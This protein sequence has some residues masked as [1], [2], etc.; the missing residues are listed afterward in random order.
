MCKMKESDHKSHYSHDWEMGFRFSDEEKVD[1]LKNSITVSR[2][3]M[4]VWMTRAITTVLLWTCFVQLMALGELWRPKLFITW[5]SRCCH[6]DSPMALQSSSSSLPYK[7]FLPPKSKL[8]VLIL[9]HFSLYDLFLTNFWC[10][11]LTGVY[12]SNGY[13]MVSCNGGLNQMRAAVS[14]FFSRTKWL[15]LG[16]V[17]SLFS[18]CLLELC[19]CL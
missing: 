10:L 13:L 15:T 19:H 3:R 4:K 16:T 14:S 7:V 8:Q 11:F 1:K 17:D 6:F 18:D 12:K 5:P 2:S 9:P